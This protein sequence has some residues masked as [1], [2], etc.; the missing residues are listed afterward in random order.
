MRSKNLLEIKKLIKLKI[1]E[2]EEDNQMSTLLRDARKNMNHSYASTST[3]SSDS[4]DDTDSDYT[5]T[6]WYSSYE[7]I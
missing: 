5:K 4:Y 2:V 1:K 6:D 7:H 3:G